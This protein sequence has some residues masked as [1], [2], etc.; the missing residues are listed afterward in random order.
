MLSQDTARLTAQEW[1]ESWNS[2]DLASIISHYSDNVEFS[3]PFKVKLMGEESGAVRGKDRLRVYFEK[4][5]SA[6]PDLKFEHQK[7]LK[8]VN[9]ITLYYMSVNDLLAAEVME[10]DS[11]NKICKVTAHY[12]ID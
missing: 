6:Y 5:L 7:I 10:L 8:G 9:S 12:S 2:H 1:I 4:G 3:S 11:E